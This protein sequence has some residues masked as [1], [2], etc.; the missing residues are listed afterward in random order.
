MEVNAIIQGVDG[1]L[2]CRQRGQHVLANLTG[3]LQ[4]GHCPAV[5]QDIALPHSAMKG[6]HDG[7]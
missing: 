2:G 3:T 6:E 1:A 4:L 5:V 7:L